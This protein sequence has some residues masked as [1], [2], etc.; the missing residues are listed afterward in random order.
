MSAEHSPRRR[1]G[2][3][4]ADSSLKYDNVIS[5]D[6]DILPTDIRHRKRTDSEHGGD[7]EVE[8]RPLRRAVS[9]HGNDVQVDIEQ[10][11][12][13]GFVMMPP[14]NA[15]EAQRMVNNYKVCLSYHSS[16]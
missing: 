4:S 10:D 15:I 1:P 11:Q 14:E 16:R 13:N 9:E 5:M 8:V 7:V 6:P 3:K 2:T 12:L